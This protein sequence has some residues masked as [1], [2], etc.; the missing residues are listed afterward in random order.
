MDERN[1]VALASP[2]RAA[3]IEG[4]PENLIRELIKADKV[5]W[6]PAG[7]RKYVVM[8]SLRAYL[9]GTEED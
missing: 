6:V 7:N 9:Y 2:H 3:T 5:R 1:T 4:I 8:R